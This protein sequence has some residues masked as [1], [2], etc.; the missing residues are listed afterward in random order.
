MFTGIIEEVGK[1]SSI[2]RSRETATM[3]VR[4]V[5]VLEGIQLG[6]SV[7]VNGVCLTVRQ[8]AEQDFQVEISS[9]TLRRIQPGRD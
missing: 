2:Q 5:K 9:E 7:A 4:A 1:V 8:V 6:D 3:T